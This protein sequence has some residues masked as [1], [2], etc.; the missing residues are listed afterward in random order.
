MPRPN[1]LFSLSFSRVRVGADSGQSLSL[2]TLRPFKSKE[3]GRQILIIYGGTVEK[4][5]VEMVRRS[6][7]M[8][9]LRLGFVVH[10][11]DF[12]SNKEGTRFHNYGLYDRVEDARSAIEWLANQEKYLPLSV[13]GVSMGVYVAIRAIAES[14]VK[15]ENL[16]LVAPAAYADAACRPD[17]KFGRKFSEI[18]RRFESWRESSIF[19]QAGQIGI[20]SDVLMIVYGRDSVIPSEITKEY[21]IAFLKSSLSGNSGSRF[22]RV[23][24]KELDHGGLF[25]DRAKRN[26]VVG[27]IKEFLSRNKKKM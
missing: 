16:I 10:C 9:L 17:I 3:F 22:C 12:R 1:L 8:D 7:A 13:L 18:I 25:T 26:S 14:H 4:N 27:V 24:L 20:S 5:F 15:V 2:T 6:L 23:T 11:F 19:K 21:E